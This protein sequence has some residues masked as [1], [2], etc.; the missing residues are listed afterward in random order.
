MSSTVTLRVGG[1]TCALCIGDIMERVHL[2]PGVV[3]VAVG[4]VE[5]G[6]SWVTV[7]GEPGVSVTRLSRELS[8]GGFHIAGA[9]GH[10][11][12]PDDIHD[13]RAR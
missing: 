10:L 2:V 3:Q 6:R 12:G 1:L 9:D 13:R 7:T 5:H 4:R 11:A 8:R